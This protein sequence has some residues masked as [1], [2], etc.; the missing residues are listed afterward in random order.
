MELLRTGGYDCEYSSSKKKILETVDPATD[1]IAIAGGDGTIRKTIIRLLNKKLKYKRPIAILPYGTA[2][3]IA[4]SLGIERDPA[5]NIASWAQA[6]LRPFDVG[7]VLGMEKSEFFIEAFGFGLFPKL[8]SELK[9]MD[10]SDNNSPDD[11][12]ELAL[13]KLFELVHHYKP[14]DC[15]IEFDGQKIKEKCLMVEVM[16]IKSMGPKMRINEDSEP[17]DGFFELIVIKERDRDV[18][19]NY[20]QQ[21]RHLEHPAFPIVPIKVKQLSIK[22]EGDDVHMDDEVI[23]IVGNPDFRISVLENLLQ[24][25]CSS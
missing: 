11:E 20:I 23:Q 6:E 19:A 4:T 16:N 25:L 14:I 22:W 17:G 2:N 1:L 9:N 24:I 10:T 7:Q 3:N 13:A 12:F 8:M 21:K 18:M 5:K 15:T